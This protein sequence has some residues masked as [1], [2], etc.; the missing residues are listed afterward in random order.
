MIKTHTLSRHVV[1]RCL[2]TVMFIL[3]AAIIPS[4]IVQASSTPLTA[5]NT[6]K[7]LDRTTPNALITLPDGSEVALPDVIDRPLLVNFWA[8]W[9]APCVHELP[10]LQVLDRALSDAGMG[11]MLIG[12]DRKGH[13]FAEGFLADRGITIPARFYEPKGTLG[14]AL[15]IKV[16]PTSYLVT[17]DGQMIGVIEGPR[18]W[19]DD[20]VIAAVKSALA[21]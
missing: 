7:P 5:L 16:M 8:S 9:C 6:M 20:D 14:R 2:G 12:I 19:A 13:A 4:A 1:L 11:V 17:A 10:D 3:A 18:N 21:P 15:Q